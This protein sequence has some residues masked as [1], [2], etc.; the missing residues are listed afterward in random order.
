MT[1]DQRRG[2]KGSDGRRKRSTSE[3]VG[4]PSPSPPKAVETPPSE[5]QLMRT[6][7]ANSIVFEWD[8]KKAQINL[9]KHG[10]SFEEA[11][12][13][14]GD[15]RTLTVFDRLHSQEEDR[16]ITLGMSTEGHVLVVVHT[17]RGRKI[18][19]ISARR[20]SPGERRAYEKG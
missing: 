16:S 8:E 20:A 15:P 9:K 1:R 14:F 19:L 17:D 4:L 6:P 3:G 10:I 11:R 7:P 2:G 18:R 12:T 13:I 5:E